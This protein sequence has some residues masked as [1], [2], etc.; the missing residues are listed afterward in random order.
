MF[1]TDL[2]SIIGSLNTVFTNVKYQNYIQKEIKSSKMHLWNDCYHFVQ[3]HLPSSL[4]PKNVKIKIDT[5]ITLHV[6][7]YGCETWSLTR[8]E[9]H[10]LRVLSEIRV[11]RI[12]GTK[13]ER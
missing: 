8:R 11:L 10:R 13:R 4:L 12:S 2:L 6:V 7:L 1:W 9:E 3:N 5:T